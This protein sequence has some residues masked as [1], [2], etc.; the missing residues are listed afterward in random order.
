[1][2]RKRSISVVVTCEHG[3]NRVPAEAQTHFRGA[4]QVLSSHRGWDPGALPLAKRFAGKLQVPLFNANVSRLVVELNRS[5]THPS[6]FSEF[7][8]HRDSADRAQLLR[9]YWHPHRDR[10]QQHIESVMNAQSIVVHLSVHTFTEVLDNEVRTTD[11][12]VLYD[13]RRKL[14]KELCSVWRRQL[15]KINSAWSIRRND[16]YRGS[17]DGF[18]TYLRKQFDPGQ[19]VGIELEVCQ[20]FFLQ[21]GAAWEEILAHVPQSFIEA[22]SEFL[23]TVSVNASR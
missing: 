7:T 16:P 6:L 2:P 4:E 10:V 14:E 11:I 13:P 3:G 20:K 23:G 22:M 12:G 9:K 17:S 15:R 5:L 21:G 8:R 18:T 1:M 19:Y